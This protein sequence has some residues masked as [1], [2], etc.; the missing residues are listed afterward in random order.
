MIVKDFKLGKHK[1]PV[2][3]IMG[4]GDVDIMN[5]YDPYNNYVMISFHNGSYNEIGVEY[6]FG[7]DHD[8]DCFDE[9]PMGLIFKDPRSIDSLMH[10]LQLSRNKL[11]QLK[12]E[13]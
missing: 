8:S 6:S 3:A 10:Q 2:V 12:E 7:D 5:S 1:I 9:I 11:A 4:N 13:E